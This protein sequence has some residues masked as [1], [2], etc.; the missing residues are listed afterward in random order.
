MTRVI[1]KG[2]S[3]PFEWE[4][5]SAT[6]NITDPFLMFWIRWVFGIIGSF[7]CN[8]ALSRVLRWYSPRWNLRLTKMSHD[9]SYFSH[10]LQ[11]RS[12]EDVAYGQP[13]CRTSLEGETYTA[14]R[15][16]RSGKPDLFTYIARRWGRKY[17]AD[18]TIKDWF[19][20]FELGTKKP[21][22]ELIE[23][24]ERV[25]QRLAGRGQLDV[26][27]SHLGLINVDLELSHP[28]Q[29]HELVSSQTQLSLSAQ[30]F[31]GWAQGPRNRE[32]STMSVSSTARRI[33]T[34]SPRRL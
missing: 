7:Y 34:S 22:E 28:H 2:N 17:E 26:I 13:R 6:L 25:K 20:S 27:Y 29:R 19:D 23:R 33:S 31:I 30:A 18:R 11:G 4:P 3:A 5:N 21:L 9:E 24:P 12:R 16:R 14:H 10:Q 32:K 15:P 1:A 8:P